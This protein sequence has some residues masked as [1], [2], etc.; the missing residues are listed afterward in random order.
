M[1]DVSIVLWFQV[2]AIN[3]CL[4]TSFFFFFPIKFSSFSECAM[5][6]LANTIQFCLSLSSHVT[7]VAETHLMFRSPL[8]IP[9]TNPYEMPRSSDSSLILTSWYSY[10]DA[11]TC[12]VSSM[13]LFMSG[14]P[15]CLSLSADVQPPIKQ[16]NHS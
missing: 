15:E 5:K 8:N 10:T 12:S 16:Y 14:L 6:L 2:T 1:M 11:V 3:P 7:N 4:I 13:F 9:W